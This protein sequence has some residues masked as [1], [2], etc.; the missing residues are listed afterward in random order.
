MHS[1]DPSYLHGTRNFSLETLRRDK[2][3]LDAVGASYL[4]LDTLRSFK[5]RLDKLGGPYGISLP[6]P[7]AK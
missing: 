2:G 6:E 4:R 3:V 7:G 1:E 5:K